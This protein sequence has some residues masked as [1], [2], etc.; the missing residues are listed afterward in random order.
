MPFASMRNRFAEGAQRYWMVALQLILVA[1][2]GVLLARLLFAVLTPVGP[3]GDIASLQQRAADERLTLRQG[4]E[5]FWA[6]SHIQA[7]RGTGDWTLHG[8]LY[9]GAPGQAGAILSTSVGPQDVYFAGDTLPNGATV[10]R[11]EKDHVVI[12]QD[13]GAERI[14]LDQGFA[15]AAAGPGSGPAGRQTPMAQAKQSV[16]RGVMLKTVLDQN[17]LSQVGLKGDDRLI[18]IA[19]QEIADIADARS[20]L[21]AAQ[22]QKRVEVTLLRGET[23]L[24]KV[25]QQ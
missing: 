15:P 22:S 14:F 10:S 1:A 24:T 5:P 16:Q 12:E 18:A 8:I 11:V 19:G 7:P 20:A 2:V 4:I 13:G 6:S 17:R 21:L 25:L 9:R 23:E 3:F